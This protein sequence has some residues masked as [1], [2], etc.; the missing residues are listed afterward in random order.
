VKRSLLALM[1]LV[2]PLASSAAHAGVLR[3]P[4]KFPTIQAAVNAAKPG[5]QIVVA[6]GLYTEAVLIDGKQQLVLR[7]QGNVRLDSKGLG[8]ALALSG[9]SAIELRGLRIV[10][11]DG[12]A[13]SV[14]SCSDVSMADC[15]LIS[16][17][18]EAGADCMQITSSA[19]VSLLHCEFRGSQAE[20]AL[21][22][23]LSGGPVTDL[24][25][26]G[27]LFIEPVLDAVRLNQVQGAELVRNL[28]RRPGLCFVDVLGSVSGVMLRGN[29]VRQPGDVALFALG[30][31]V[32]AVHNQVSG[33]FSAGLYLQGSGMLASDNRI[34]SMFGQGLLL[35]GAEGQLLRNTIAGCGENGITADGLHLVV[36]D[37]VIEGVQGAGIQLTGT[38]H[39]VERN[40]ISG[41]VLYGLSVNAPS[42]SARDNVV[43]GDGALPLLAGVLMVGDGAVFSG[44]QVSGS[45]HDGFVLSGKNGHISLNAALDSAHDGFS[46]QGSG[47]LLSGNTASG[48][49]HLDLFELKLGQNSIDASNVFG[50]SNAP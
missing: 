9:C 17:T 37:N 16:R 34:S 14:D 8:V 42:S 33:G 35:F 1:V 15:A 31:D 44:N 48:S 32:S 49:G 24:K 19:G 36:S 11:A 4:A 41:A 2:S 21:D 13:V 26:T 47:C 6:Q 45:G 38:G 30:S 18:P 50:S 5:D 12:M 7:G 46:L 22:V 39:T 20:G 10:G 40:R 43:V 3:V 27:C 29:R 25:L 28:V 23:G